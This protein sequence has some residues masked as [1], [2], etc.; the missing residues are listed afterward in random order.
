MKTKVTGI[1]LAAGG[2]KRLGRPKQLL[3]WCGDSYIGKTIKTAQSSGL[4]PIFVITGA[5]QEEI[6]NEITGL[7]VESVFNPNW[8]EG[9]SSSMRLGAEAAGKIKQ[10]FIYLLC[11][12][13]QIPETL[14]Q[15]I[16][17]ASEDP[18]FDVVGTKVMGKVV[19]PTLFKP[20][21]INDIMALEGDIGAKSVMQK[22]P[23]KF[24]QW[25]DEGLLLDC[26]TEDDYIK[27]KVFYK[28][29]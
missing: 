13:P 24:I 26:D 15:M 17:E 4:D 12:H 25:E 23:I 7:D 6:Q 11:D 18:A 9:Q 10:P 27:Q 28:C 29:V 20:N 14:I 16:V 2:S 8:E 3:D 21:C 1:V 22:H 5:Y 19:P